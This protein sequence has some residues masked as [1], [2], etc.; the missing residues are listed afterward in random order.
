MSYFK[1]QR[2]VLSQ[3]RDLEAVITYFD[4]SNNLKSSKLVHC[5][6]PPQEGMLFP[7]HADTESMLGDKMLH[8]KH[9]DQTSCD[10]L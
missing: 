9:K 6:R 4:L 2:P 8:C 7:L 1:G 5:V 10:I 3:E